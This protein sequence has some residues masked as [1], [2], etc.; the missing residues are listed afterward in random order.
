MDLYEYFK[1]FADQGVKK[2]IRYTSNFKEISTRLSNG[3]PPTIKQIYYLNDF[4][5]KYYS[6][7]S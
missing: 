3:K 5:E 4:M 6:V 2:G 1:A 7:N